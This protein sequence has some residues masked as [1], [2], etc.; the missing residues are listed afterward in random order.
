VYIWRHSAIFSGRKLPN[1]LRNYLE[2]GNFFRN[3][4]TYP[5][6]YIVSHPIRSQI[7]N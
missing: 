6:N 3:E 7:L 2:I 5:Q 4:G 1:I